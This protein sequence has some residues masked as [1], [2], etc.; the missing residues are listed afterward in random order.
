MN[1]NQ[2]PKTLEIRNTTGGPI[3][4]I[5]HVENQQEVDLLTKTATGNGFFSITLVDYRPDEP[6]NWPGWRETEGWKARI[7]PDME[8]VKK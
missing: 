4:Q 1:A 3:W 5:Y 2:F 8:E 6:E 7:S